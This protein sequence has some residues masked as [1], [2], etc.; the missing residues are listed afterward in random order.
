MYEMPDARQ[1]QALVEHAG[2][3]GPLG[4]L[5]N[6][7]GGWLAGPQYPDTDQWHRALDLNLRMPVLATQLA[8][9]FMAAAGGGAVVNVASSGAFGP[10]PYGSPE[11]AAAKAVSSASRQ[12][13]P[14]SGNASASAPAVSF[15]IGSG[16]SVPSCSSSR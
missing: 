10:R 11:Y 16:W 8:L 13:S 1:V 3:I 2:A 14:T 12:P 9:P 6:N 15:H 5:V 7:A 4:V